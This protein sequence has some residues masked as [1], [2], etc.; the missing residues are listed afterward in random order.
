MTH[1]SL[2]FD[3]PKTLNVEE[4]KFYGRIT[5]QCRILQA[6]RNDYVM[7]YENNKQTKTGKNKQW[8]QAN[9]NIQQLYLCDH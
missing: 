6:R 9:H 7:E 3:A 1:A 8:G 4:K 2:P 5:M